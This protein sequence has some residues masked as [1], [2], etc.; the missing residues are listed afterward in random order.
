MVLVETAP[1]LPQLS[2]IFFVIVPL[3]ELTPTA[4]VNVGVATVPLAWIV[5][6][7]NQSLF[8]LAPRTDPKLRPLRL[9]WLVKLLLPYRTVITLLPLG[10]LGNLTQILV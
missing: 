3:P 5:L 10:K 9:L 8:V 4:L 7:F 2:P 1:A 6:E